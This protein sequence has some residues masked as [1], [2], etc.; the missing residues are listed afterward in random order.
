ML[1]ANL[2]MFG[3]VVR[4]RL[5]S[6]DAPHDVSGGASLE[7]ITPFIKY[8][9]VQVEASPAFTFCLLNSHFVVGLIFYCCTL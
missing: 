4:L 5:N 8:E 7:D 9:I 1:H 6:R 3:N 2:I